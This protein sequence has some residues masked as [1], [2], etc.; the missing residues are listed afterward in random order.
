VCG[1][2]GYLERRPH[3]GAPVGRLAKEML[4]ALGRRGP[5]SAGVAL[6][7]KVA[8]DTLRVRVALPAGAGRLRTGDDPG[9]DPGGQPGGGPSA[10]LPLVLPPAEAA[11]EALA[12]A[13]AA[14]APLLD[15]T[16]SGPEIELWVGESADVCGLERA[17]ETAVPG[18][19]VLCAGRRLRLLKQVGL[20]ADLEA[21]YHL[22]TLSGSHLI[23]HTRMA[24]ESRVDLSH[25][26]PFWAH[27]T[28]DLAVVHNGHITNYH[29]LRRRYEQQGH[30]F[31]T[32]N[33]S[34][35]IGLYLADQ[36]RRDGVSLETAM[37][38]SLDDLDGS[39][40]YL[41]GSAE[42]IGY[43]KDRFGLKPLLLVEEADFVALATEEIALHAA[44][45]PVAARE[46][47][48]GSTR[49]WEDGS[50]RLSAAPRPPEAALR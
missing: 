20:A 19:E 22:S 24:T 30:R 31:Y 21:T 17:I 32:E 36:M 15:A 48:T 13:V 18:A 43:A 50:S 14:H 47:P 4:S 39:F 5:D 44:L 9:A 40:S 10:C 12:A 37:R 46:L 26:Q 3:P 1:I 49:F 23:G 7:D 28:L 8:G 11:R 45:G 29:Q 33:D 38:R 41:V 6:Y 42:G 35:I 27:G 16:I 34:E 2:I 25:S